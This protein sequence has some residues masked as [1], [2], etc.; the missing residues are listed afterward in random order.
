ML[1]I[2][3][4]YILFASLGITAACFAVTIQN[5]IHGIL[6]L[7]LVFLN[8][9]C[10]LLLLKM[11][12]FAL[13]LITVFIGAVAILFLFVI[14]I[15]NIKIKEISFKSF[16]FYNF[17]WKISFIFLISILFNYLFLNIFSY[18]TFNFFELKYN[19][20]QT[21]WN[22]S[23]ILIIFQISNIEI[24]GSLLYSEYY[25]HFILASILLFIAM[26]ASII[27]TMQKSKKIK[28]QYYAVQ[29]SK[30]IEKTI[31]IIEY[32][33]KNSVLNIQEI[34]MNSNKNIIIR[35][36]Y[37]LNNPNKFNPI[38]LKKINNQKNKQIYSKL[39]NFS[40]NF[41]NIN[42]TLL[43]NKKNINNRL[44]QINLIFI[45]NNYIFFKKINKIEFI[46][47]LIDINEV[48]KIFELYILIIIRK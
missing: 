46:H 23:W 12:F 33:I 5:A 10:I 20:L 34:L 42:I 44:S 27:L 1:L 19:L 6:Y 25:I 29:M 21:F 2:Y 8:I 16:F 28:R 22:F 11:D 9:A 35:A 15:I 48:E 18:L 41:K 24:L 45:L 32:P 30:Q 13:C 26:I 14:M 3:L 47:Y 38:S 40:L 7:I 17:L 4:F 36:V 37:Y 43:N 39:I 31:H